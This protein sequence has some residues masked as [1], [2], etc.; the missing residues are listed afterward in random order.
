MHAF[1][2]VNRSRKGARTVLDT[3]HFCARS[4]SFGAFMLNKQNFMLSFQNMTEQ[5]MASTVAVEGLTN[6]LLETLLYP[7]RGNPVTG[8]F[9]AKPRDVAA[10]FLSTS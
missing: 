1:V 3:F 4:Q 5:I 8:R 6:L 9:I 7:E 10:E 2:D